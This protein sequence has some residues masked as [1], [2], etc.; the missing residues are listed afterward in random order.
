MEAMEKA[1]KTM[2]DEKS[3]Q[4]VVEK[5]KKQSMTP[6]QKKAAIAEKLKKEEARLEKIKANKKALEKKLEQIDNPPPNRKQDA[7][8]KIL[9]GVTIMEM[10]EKD[11]ELHR[12]VM[13]QIDLVTKRESDRKLLGL[14]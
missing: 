8:K 12:K 9:F 4:T 7:R 13:T 11:P 6:E 1:G 5:K 14:V 3:V 10:M 2:D